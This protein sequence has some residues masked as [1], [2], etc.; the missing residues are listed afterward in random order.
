MTADNS[1]LLSFASKAK[2]NPYKQPEWKNPKPCIVCGNSFLPYQKKSVVCSPDC[3]LIHV[4]N[5]NRAKWQSKNYTEINCKTCNTLFKPR[6]KNGKYCSKSC[7]SKKASYVVVNCANCKKTVKRNRHGSN[8]RAQYCSKE[9]SYTHRVDITK[10]IHALRRIAQNNKKK[11]KIDTYVLNEIKAIK[12]I[13]RNAKTSKECKHCGQIVYSKYALLHPTCRK[14]YKVI[15]KEQYKQT[16]S[17]KQSKK[18]ARS[19]R[20]ALERG[21]TVAESINPDFI[22]ERDKYRCYI[23]GV[24]TPKRLRGT[25]EDRAPEV[26]HVIPLS[27]GGLHVE[28]NLRCSCRK[29]N[30]LKSDRV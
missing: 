5:N 25:Y 6:Q 21:A 19:R 14:E 29:C 11:V 9:C 28:S 3:S 2:T 24:K 18:A 7:S 8:D 30:G 26:D 12:Q 20:K 10:E 17:Y 27:K 4:A 1:A 22:L 16:D 23:C 13:A 15:K